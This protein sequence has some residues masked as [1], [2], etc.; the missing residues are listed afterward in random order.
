M[1]KKGDELCIRILLTGLVLFA[2]NINKIDEHCDYKYTL[3]C[4]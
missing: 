1:S 4:L 3:Y 2:N